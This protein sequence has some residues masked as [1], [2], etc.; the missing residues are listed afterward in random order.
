[1]G[2]NKPT[3]RSHITSLCEFMVYPS[4]GTLYGGRMYEGDGHKCCRP[5]TVRRDGKNLCGKHD[6][7]L[8]AKDIKE[9]GEMDE[10]AEAVYS[11]FQRRAW[12]E[13][14]SA[15]VEARRQR[16]AGQREAERARRVAETAAR[17]AAWR[18]RNLRTCVTCARQYNAGQLN[19]GECWACRA[20]RRQAERQANRLGGIFGRGM[21]LNVQSD[22]PKPEEKPLSE[23]FNSKRRFLHEDEK[24]KG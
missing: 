16:E 23:V 22:P 17:A 11:P 7:E 14:L 9:I 5:A 1:M 12:S 3:L 2:K 24:T 4:D 19:P 13:E 6:S 20:A 21:P 10:R 18:A 8:S 15:R